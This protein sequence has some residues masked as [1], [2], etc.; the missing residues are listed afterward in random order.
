VVVLRGLIE[1]KL[2]AKGEVVDAEIVPEPAL[3]S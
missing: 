3:N 2:L 1:K